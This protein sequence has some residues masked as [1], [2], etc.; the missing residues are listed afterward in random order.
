MTSS[1]LETYIIKFQHTF[2]NLFFAFGYDVIY[3]LIFSSFH[4]QKLNDIVNW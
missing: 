2:Y 3:N 1:L 4:Q